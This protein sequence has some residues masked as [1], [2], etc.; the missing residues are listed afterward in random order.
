MK[1][2][3]NEMQKARRFPAARLLLAGIWALMVLFLLYQLIGFSL[4][5][6]KIAVTLS[7]SPVSTMLPPLEKAGKLDLNTATMAQLDTLPGIGPVLAG[8]II[9]FRE[10]S[11][12]FYFIE[13]LMDVPGIGE[14]KF[15]ALQDLVCCSYPESP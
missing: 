6:K 12:A 9:R 14:K 3:P 10:E 1:T 7:P 13:E 11:G 4:S 2:N 15:S 5:H 8:E